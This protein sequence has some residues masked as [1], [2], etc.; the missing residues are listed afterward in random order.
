MENIIF[1]DNLIGKNKNDTI[2]AYYKR[3]LELNIDNATII[4]KAIKKLGYFNV[5]ANVLEQKYIKLIFQQYFIDFTENMS[6]NDIKQDD[7]I[8]IYD[9]YMNIINSD[10]FNKYR[11]S[12]N[13]IIARCNELMPCVAHNDLLEFYS[14]LTLEELNSLGY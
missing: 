2:N 10:E 4:T 13:N 5:N 6:F 11:N 12:I 3:D 14:K 7:S 9:I 8:N 1:N